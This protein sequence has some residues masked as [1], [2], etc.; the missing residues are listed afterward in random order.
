MRRI[1]LGDRPAVVRA[2]RDQGVWVP[3]KEVG[4]DSFNYVSLTDGRIAL[5]VGDV[6]GK[7][8][9]SF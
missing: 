1:A 7:G 2:D 5:L 8:V 9:E 4:G 3:A 6:S